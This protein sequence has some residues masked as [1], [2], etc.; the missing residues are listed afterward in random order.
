MNLPKKITIVEVSL[1]DGLQNESVILPT[2]DKVILINSLIESGIKN[3]E[4]T[5]FVHP[6]WVPQ[7]ADAEVL[8]RMIPESRDVIYSTIVPNMKGFERLK[9]TSIKEMTLIISASEKHNKK[10]LNCTIS[11]SLNDLEAICKNLKDRKIRVKGEISMSFG[12]PFEGSIPLD[13]VEWIVDKFNKMGVLDIILADT[14][15]I[16]NPRQVYDMFS[17][18]KKLFKEVSFAAHLHDTNKM[19]LANI[20]AAINAGITI[21][22]SS[23]GGLGGCPF[24]PGASGNVATENLVYMATAMGIDTGIN[25]LKLL[26]SI[27]VLEKLLN[28]KIE[29][30]PA[31]I[32]EI[33]IY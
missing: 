4:A 32:N 22:D 11:E 2:G 14:I 6:K 30:I 3:I 20:L 16:A 21:F 19:A 10:N 9:E 1:R 27:K 28:R 31:L 5:S 29:L 25:L 23:I 17:S 26:Q 15:G 18:M 33:N 8:L 13:R 24:A 12:C 7:L